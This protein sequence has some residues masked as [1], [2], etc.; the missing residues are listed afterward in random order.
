MPKS[1][2]RRPLRIVVADDH[3]FLREL[4]R[5]LFGQAPDSYAVV[6]EVGNADTAIAAC[7]EHKPDLLVLDVK[8]PGR[9]GIEAVPDVRRASPGTRILLCSGSVN[10]QDI[11]AAIRIGVEGFMEKTSSREDFLAA[12]ERVRRGEHYFCPRSSRLLLEIARG[13]HDQPGARKSILSRR[14]QEVLA[15]IAAGQTNK[16]IASAL[17]ISYATVETHRR[18]LMLK[19]GAHNAAD[20]IRFGHQEGLLAASANQ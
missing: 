7:R 13:L 15:L 9:S 4:L 12:V 3:V 16:E 18:N 5:T 6:A 10:E 17:G 11:M 19:A 14:Q 8:L 20:L 1:L 2:H